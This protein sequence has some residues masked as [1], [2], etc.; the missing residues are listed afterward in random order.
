MN[1]G[2]SEPVKLSYSRINPDK[3]STITTRQ[4]I[5]TYSPVC[6]KGILKIEDENE[7]TLFPFGYSQ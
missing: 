5:K 1:Y 6:K 3:Y 4:Q 7:M 2:N